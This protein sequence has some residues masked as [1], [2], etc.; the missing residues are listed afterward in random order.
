[1]GLPDHVAGTP[2][3]LRLRG[4][5]TF[6]EW[7]AMGRRL[8]RITNASPWWLG[9]WLVYGQHAYGDRY[10]SAIEVTGL[11]YQTLRNYAW[12]A[13][14]F[15]MSRRRDTLSFQ[16][17]A[18]VAALQE[19]DQELW[20]QRAVTFGWSKAALRRNLVAEREERRRRGQDVVSVRVEVSGA[21][22]ERWQRAATEAGLELPEWVT[23]A[24]DAVAGATLGETASPETGSAVPM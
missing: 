11:N 2:S 10:A 13:R 15:I 18:E 8:S 7:L 21:R 9:D 3:A 19:P 4:D 5:I 22:A 6:D 23:R 24:A 17:H 20:L 12:V 16:H 14:R 1:M